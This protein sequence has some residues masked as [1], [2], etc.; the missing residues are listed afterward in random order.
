MRQAV[1]CGITIV[2]IGSSGIMST[3]FAN[4]CTHIQA[5]RMQERV[6]SKASGNELFDC[7]QG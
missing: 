4:I 2:G 7:Y 6:N 5:S 1:D 3:G